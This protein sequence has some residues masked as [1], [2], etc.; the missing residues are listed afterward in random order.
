M[1]TASLL[2][3]VDLQLRQSSHNHDQLKLQN[4]EKNEFADILNG[5]LD[6]L[7]TEVDDNKNDEGSNVEELY[8][9]EEGDPKTKT[10]S[11]VGNDESKSQSNYNIDL[12]DNKNDKKLSTAT[13]TATAKDGRSNIDELNYSKW[14]QK[15]VL[16]WIKMNLLNNQF[17]H[18]IIK[19]FLIELSQKCITGSVIE[20][21][22]YQPK[23]I[24]ALQMQFSKENQAFGIWLVIESVIVSIGNEN[25]NENNNHVKA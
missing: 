21:L 13:A 2:I 12:I 14:T 18:E 25:E 4:G 9:M 22:K 11:D 6:D 19:S 20:K 3:D 1:N 8:K 7:D 24:H 23:L 16:M 17:D 15:E 10:G 5:V